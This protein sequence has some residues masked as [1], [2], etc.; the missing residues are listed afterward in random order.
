VQ[1]E[2]P[3]HLRYVLHNLPEAVGIER[4]KADKVL[5]TLSDTFL[6]SRG[7]YFD[8]KLH[9]TQI[10]GAFKKYGLHI[11]DRLI[12]LD[13]VRIANQKELREYLQKRKAY[14]SMLFERNG[15]QFFVNI[16]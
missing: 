5:E 15:F 11:G 1:I 2:Q 7:L 10:G 9:L 3:I 14:S 12:Q 8:V 4:E 13:G 6:E 16:K